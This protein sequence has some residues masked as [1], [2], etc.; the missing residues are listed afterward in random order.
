[1]IVSH[2]EDFARVPRQQVAESAL[3]GE[4]KEAYRLTHVTIKKVT[5]DIEGSWHF[6]T[7]IAFVITLVNEVGKLPLRDHYDG[8]ESE[9]ELLNFNAFRFAAESIVQM[10][11]PFV[12]HVCEELWERLGNQ[13]S[14]FRQ[15]WPQ[16]DEAAARAEQVELPVQ[17]N[18]RVRD[19]LVAARDEAE[20]VVRA[21]AL[22]LENVK[23][24]IEG[25]H[26]RQVVI[27]PNRIVNIIV[28]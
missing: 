27:V 4:W 3:S 22:D 15:G 28:N 26:V 13:P 14:I 9:A 2:Q 5:G 7:A 20:D 6:N 8:T 1:M 12:P 23:R 17:V 25:K 18:G 21:R 16:F 11:A 24:H 19:R 10:L